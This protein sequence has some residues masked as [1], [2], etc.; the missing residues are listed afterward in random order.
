ML[1]IMLAQS[2]KAYTHVSTV[3]IGSYAPAGPVC[4][5]MLHKI[6]F[7]NTAGITENSQEYRKQF[8]VQGFFLLR[9]GGGGGGRM[10]HGEFENSQKL[11]QGN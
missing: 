11:D 5:S 8:L 2:T 10:Y 3:R 7:S 9:G 1:K 6:L 4:S